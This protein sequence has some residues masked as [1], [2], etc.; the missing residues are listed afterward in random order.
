MN[1]GCAGCQERNEF[2]V[3]TDHLPTSLSENQAAEDPG[4]GRSSESIL[5]EQKSIICEHGP[6]EQECAVV[7]NE[8]NEDRRGNTPMNSNDKNKRKNRKNEE[9]EENDENAL[10][11]PSG[12]GSDTQETA[13]MKRSDIF[14][15]I[16]SPPPKVI[17]LTLPKSP[18]FSARFAADLAAAAGRPAP[19]DLS[20]AFMS[21]NLPFA[22]H[23]PSAGFRFAPTSPMCSPIDRMLALRACQTQALHPGLQIGTSGGHTGN[24]LNNITPFLF[25]YSTAAAAAAAGV[26][27]ALVGTS[28]YHPLSPFGLPLSLD[29]KNWTLGHDFLRTNTQP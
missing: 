7:E 14:D 29:T 5:T 22:L 19:Y 25:Q 8:C 16:P 10:A 13:A 9:E 17:D 2:D 23:H 26:N 18:K 11:A 28:P 21:P 1:A 12:S 3:N 6:S 20:S 15:K 4:E 24:A 27:P